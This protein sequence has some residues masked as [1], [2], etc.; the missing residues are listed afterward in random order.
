[1]AST[2]NRRLF[3]LSTAAAGWVNRVAA[4]D[5]DDTDQPSLPPPPG[6]TVLF[7]GKDLS[8]WVA[9]K[10]GGPPPW[11]VENGYVET[12]A[13]SGGILTREQYRDFQLHVEFRIPDP[14]GPSRGNSGIYLQGR[15]EVQIMDSY[16]RPPELGG[17]GALYREVPPLRNMSKRPGRWQTF[18]IA[19]RAPRYAEA[20]GELKQKGL[21]TVFHNQVMVHNNLEI[22]GMTGQAKRNPKNDPRQPGPILLQN[23]GSPVRFRNLWIIPV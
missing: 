7:D 8:A 3:F 10:G 21:L 20:G 11:K 9:E 12:T 4:A 23:H 2:M 18:D 19:F 15:Y 17:C 1:M 5:Q 16:G 22:P 6:A 14:V 13:G